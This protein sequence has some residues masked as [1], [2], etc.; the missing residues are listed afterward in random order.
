MSSVIFLDL[1]A[2]ARDVLRNSG[3]MY[4]RLPGCKGFDFGFG[5]WAGCGHVYGLLDAA[6]M[7]AAVSNPGPVPPV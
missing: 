1:A 7:T 6:L 4:G 5:G 2:D 3:D